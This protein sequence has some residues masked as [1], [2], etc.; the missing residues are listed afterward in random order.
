MQFARSI[1]RLTRDS[2]LPEDD[3]INVMHW[4]SSAEASDADVFTAITSRIDA[5]FTAMQTWLGSVLTGAG[6]TEVYDMGDDPPRVPWG[7]DAF[8]FTPS[9]STCLPE[10]V[11]VCLSMQATPVSGIPQAR[12]R[13][14]IYVGP[15]TTGAVSI[16]NG[17]TFVA[18][19]L[20]NA[21][22]AAADDLAA[23]DTSTSTQ[24]AVFSRQQLQETGSME[25]A[26]TPVSG[27]WVDDAFDIQRR[28]GS[29]S[30]NRTLWTAGPATP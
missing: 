7:N 19:N 21:L 15:L 6:V 5:F 18:T 14:R 27:G 29:R 24:L 22:I 20:R 13:G 1:T 16:E 23:P 28:R 3:V 26:F 11:A 2:G 10:E 30:R 25:S 12:R 9:A 17:G 4:R 8:T